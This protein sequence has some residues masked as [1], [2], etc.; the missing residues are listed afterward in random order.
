MSAGNNCLAEEAALAAAQK[1]LAQKTKDLAT[2]KATQQAA[3]Q[4]A[5]NADSKIAQA[6]KDKASDQARVDADN[7]AL[8]AGGS[9]H[10][11]DSDQVSQLQANLAR[12]QDDLRTYAA[13]AQNEQQYIDSLEQAI[14]AKAAA[15]HEADLAQTAVSDAQS[16]VNADQA[17]LDACRKRQAS[18]SVISGSPTSFATTTNVTTS[19]GT[20]NAPIPS[21]SNSP[22]NLGTANTQ[23]P[24]Q[25]PAPTDPA[26]IVPAATTVS[27]ADGGT[28]TVSTF[29]NPDPSTYAPPTFTSTFYN[30]A[31][32]GFVGPTSPA[33]TPTAGTTSFGLPGS[34]V[35]TTFNGSF[36]TRGGV[37]I[38]GGVT[39]D[40][41]TLNTTFDAGNLN[42]SFNANF[43]GGGDLGGLGGGGDGSGTTFIG[44]GTDG[45]GASA[46]V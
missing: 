20:V 11:T 33:T 10:P 39:P 24:I 19:T 26:L 40:S 42:G 21:I 34:S 31:L 4:K 16:I 12:Y 3:A 7:N 9:L 45:G 44:G 25:T 28:T 37:I 36:P 22:S 2:A 29:P 38:S 1:D 32:G 8:A 27:V 13:A 6:N 14:G 46:D 18:S 35:N 41:G 5:A 23:T 15:D 43:N 30:P 17:A